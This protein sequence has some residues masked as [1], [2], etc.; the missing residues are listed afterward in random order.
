M[1][2]SKNL[3]SFLCSPVL[4]CQLLKLVSDTVEWLPTPGRPALFEEFGDFSMSFPLREVL[5]EVLFLSRMKMFL[6][7]DKLCY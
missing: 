1:H 5:S 4:L 3:V 6:I 7:K 2:C